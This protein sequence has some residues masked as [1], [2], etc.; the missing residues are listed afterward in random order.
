VKPFSV[1]EI[2]E[3]ILRYYE[4]IDHDRASAAIIA[5]QRYL[6]EMARAAFKSEAPAKEPPLKEPVEK[7]EEKA[8]EKK[9]EVKEESKAVNQDTKDKKENADEK[10]E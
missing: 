2:G 6:E 5:C 10:K 4:K 3:R 1:R 9:D 7:K 8:E